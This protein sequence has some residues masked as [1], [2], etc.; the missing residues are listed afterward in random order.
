MPYVAK[1]AVNVG[2]DQK[3][4]C[5]ALTEKWTSELRITDPSIRHSVEGNVASIVFPYLPRIDM[6]HFNL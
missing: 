1:Q 4:R 2:R 3:T 6:N 5:T